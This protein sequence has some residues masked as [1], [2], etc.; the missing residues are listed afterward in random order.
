MKCYEKQTDVRGMSRKEGG[1]GAKIKKSA[2][3]DPVICII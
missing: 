2:C 1:V 3:A